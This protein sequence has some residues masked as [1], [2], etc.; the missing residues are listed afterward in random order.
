MSRFFH[1]L[2]LP[3]IYKQFVATL[4][5]CMPVLNSCHTDWAFSSIFN[6]SFNPT[7]TGGKKAKKYPRGKKSILTIG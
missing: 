6:V 5:V 1:C 4:K 2:K 7:K 3:D